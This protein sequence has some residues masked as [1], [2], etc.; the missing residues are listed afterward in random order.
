MGAPRSAHVWSTFPEGLRMSNA[1]DPTTPP[2]T[3]LA[4]TAT[5]TISIVVLAWFLDNVDR[6]LVAFALPVIGT[7]FSAT[8]TQLGLVVS[9]FTLSVAL[10]KIPAGL[11]VDKFG[12][13]RLL[14]VELIAWAGFMVL[15][16]FSSTLW[17]LIALRVVFGFAAGLMGVS[18]YKMVG[19]R[20]IPRW[21]TVGSSSIMTA[22]LVAIAVVPLVVAPLM[23]TQAWRPLFMWASL[24]GLVVAGYVWFFMPKPLPIELR[25][26][27]KVSH[28]DDLSAWRLL[29]L[30]A[31]WRFGLLA[32]LMNLITF[33]LFFWGPTYLI[34]ERG[35]DPAST[36]WMTSVAFGAMGVAVVGGSLLFDRVFS[37][38]PRLLAAPALLVSSLL[39][40]PMV[41]AETAENFVLF[42]T[43][44]L[45]FSGFADVTVIGT[46]MRR[47]PTRAIGAVMGVQGMGSFLGGFVSPLMIGYISDQLSF[48]AAFS[49]L[50][51][52]TALAALLFLAV[53]PDFLARR[54]E[55]V[56]V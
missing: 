17:G 51:F 50:I 12:P 9:G 23:A 1:V 38:K 43:L 35:V 39:M 49:V 48:T 47:V 40:I 16:G 37:E 7:E 11:L 32:A 25:E 2:D 6:A 24:I 44:A 26:E 33:G 42:Q 5:V 4:R 18:T 30:P 53:K 52:T 31:V 8:N 54:L 19:E 46:I 55:K 27:T 14:T 3:Q 36:G 21:R 15:I 13:R 34:R 41:L 45:V 28:D 29:R 56:V 20:I 22:N 10:M